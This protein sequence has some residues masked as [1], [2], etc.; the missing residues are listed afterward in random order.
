MFFEVFLRSYTYYIILR[1]RFANL[2][3]FLIFTVNI[4]EICVLFTLTG[5]ARIL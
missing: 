2:K 3:F 5:T 4:V 1:P